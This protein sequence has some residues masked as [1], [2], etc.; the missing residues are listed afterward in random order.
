MLGQSPITVIRLF[1]AAAIAKNGNTTSALVDL[2]QIS[3]LNRFSVF[4]TVAGTGTVKMEYL[5]G[6]EKTG[7][8]FTGATP[9]VSAAA[10]GGASDLKAFVPELAPWLKIKLTENNVNP[11]TALDLWLMIQ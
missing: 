11:I 5:V 9:I 8:Y 6:P 1:S 3:Q 4:Y 2:R 7:T 10:S